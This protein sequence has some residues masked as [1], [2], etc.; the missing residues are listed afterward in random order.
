MK[1]YGRYLICLLSI[2]SCLVFNYSC[3][4]DPIYDI[5]VWL[6]SPED[7]AEIN[8]REVT[9]IWSYYFE[10]NDAI[11][12]DIYIGTSPDNL[13]AVETPVDFID[14]TYNLT[15]L[16]PIT[17]YYWAV[18]SW[19]DYAD[20]DH[21]IYRRYYGYSDTA[22]FTTTEA[23]WE[24]GYPYN[25]YPDSG[26]VNVDSILTMHW[27]Y[28]N[29][30]TDDFDF[31]VFLGT[32]I[33]PPLVDMGIADSIRN[34]DT[35]AGGTTYYWRVVAYSDDDTSESNL[36]Y[37]TT[38]F[39]P[40]IEVYAQL[41]A[42][43]IQAPSGYHVQEKIRARFDSVYAAG[44]VS[45]RQADSVYCEDIKLD[46]DETN[47]NYRYT[48]FS[49]PFIENGQ[50]VDFTVYGNSDVPYL[51]ADIVFPACTLAVVSPEAF[52]TVS[53]NGFEVTWNGF[54][55][56][57]TVWITLLSG[58]DSTGVMKETDNDGTDSLTA[59]DLAPLGGQAD[60]YDLVIFMQV[61]QNI[62]A[63][64]YLPE[65]VIRARAINVMPQVYI[66]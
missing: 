5:E 47:Q 45:P 66:H 55:C 51:G 56:G 36:W 38:T 31:D 10:G 32:A 43:V 33:D 40:G 17:T 42:D 34:L 49:M 48:E 60:Y 4:C 13:E 65:S 52:E 3:T 9:L 41:E 22:S 1:V 63:T 27:S 44:P 16:E 7:G 6:V 11:Y 54:N 8:D 53:L 15:S 30:N 46:W 21:N 19:A 23:L 64:G 61:Q 14:T 37:F 2:L 29:P 26:A 25:P 50:N 39:A 57:S 28:Y 20:S 35:L 24:L 58:S 12:H 18:V 62:D 59:S